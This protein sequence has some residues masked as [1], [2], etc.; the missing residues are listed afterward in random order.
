MLT[1]VDYLLIAVMAISMVIGLWR[2][3]V[4]EVLSLTVWVAAFWLAVLFG[5]DLARWLDSVQQPAIRQFL[6][7]GGV[8]LATLLMGAIAVRLIGKLI[9]VSGLTVIDRLLGVGFGLIRG[10]ALACSLV[11]GLGF[12]SLQQQPDWRE[13]SLLPGFIVGALWMRGFLPAAASEQ[14]HVGLET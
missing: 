6:G 12:T 7:Y 14:N 9:A 10:Y 2:G 11:L 8:F 1:W 5:G 4:V 13:S 3:L